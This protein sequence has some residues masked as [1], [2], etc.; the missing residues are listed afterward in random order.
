MQHTHCQH[1]TDY[2]TDSMEAPLPF[3]VPLPE[4]CTVRGTNSRSYNQGQCSRRPC[5]TTRGVCADSLLCCYEVG[6]TSKVDFT[7]SQSANH[8]QGSVIVMCKCQV[9]D[10]LHAQIKGRVLSS[11]GHQPVVLA[12]ILIGN[13]IASF[14]N[15]E[16]YFF[17]ELSTHNREVTLLFEEN[18]HRQLVKMVDVYGS[19]TPEVVVIME[20]IESI[21]TID[22]IHEVFL[23]QLSSEDTVKNYGV[24]ASLLSTTLNS[25]VYPL[26]NDPYE[27]PGRVLHSLYH[28]DS[29]PDYFSPAVK[30]M[31]YRDTNG[32]EFSIQSYVMGSLEVVGETGH[33]LVLKF[34]RQLEL[35]VS[36]KFDV[37][38]KE[39]NIVSLHL[40]T[41]THSDERW[42]DRGKANIVSVDSIEGE[43][44]TRIAVSGIL[45]DIKTLWAIGFPNR[46]TCYIKTG[47]T[48]SD[49][50]Q[51][52]IGPT[53][54]IQQ[55]DN[56][57]NR[58]TFYQYSTETVAGVG[59]C[60]KGVCALGGM[61]FVSESTGIHH[62]VT[63]AIPP[64]Q[65]TGIIMGDKDHIMFYAAEKNQISTDGDTPYYLTEEACS[66]NIKTST[67]SFRF[68]RNSSLYDII[69][70]SVMPL[71]QVGGELDSR[72]TEFC[73]IK[74]AI[75]DCSPYSEVK[76][77]S[78]STEQH[79]VLLSMYVDIV[80]P[81]TANPHLYNNEGCDSSS[82]VEIRATCIEFTCE[83]DV[84][85]SVQSRRVGGGTRSDATK[86]C[87]YWSSYSIVD[88]PSLSLSSF[89]L[90]DKRTTRSSGV[91]HGKNREL[92]LMT[93]NSGDKDAPETTVDPYRGT[94]VTFTCQ[95]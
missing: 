64:N 89:H 36:I 91:Y 58:P 90:R 79:N 30:Q 80:S 12:A 1:G 3:E 8:L 23:V 63:E 88:H 28:T 2:D 55:N 14:T 44:G 4:E 5:Q 85:V 93:C 68:E 15:Q 21:L 51:E 6:Q 78:Y 26:T 94:A 16:G 31:V 10:K 67:G 11:R 83:S 22:K 49:T 13:E 77:L 86:D 70:P 75:Y 29:R 69:H 95:F 59:A 47:L 53:M 73:F 72:R 35:E 39:S 60:L 52:L 92:A 57:L 40:F 33:P 46:I 32:A 66:Q 43:Y 41:Y 7:C 18:K 17:F 82:I 37:P 84:H 76:V 62:A 65:N 45:R 20:Y 74:V 27:G 48:H 19:I 87:R 34:G 9:C 61:L 42:V 71:V 54:N 24:N 50:E 81:N 25:F 38:I 56:S